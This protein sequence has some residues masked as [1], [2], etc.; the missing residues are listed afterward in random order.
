MLIFYGIPLNTSLGN[1]HADMYPLLPNLIGYKFG[2]GKGSSLSFGDGKGS[3]LSLLAVRCNENKKKI[4]KY[5]IKITRCIV[6]FENVR[7]VKI[8]QRVNVHMLLDVS[9]MQYFLRT[10]L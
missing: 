9:Y 10:K 5:I 1:S 7:Q 6:L 2:D 3:S 8:Q 4:K